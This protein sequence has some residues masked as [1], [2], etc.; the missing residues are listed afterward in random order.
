M[1]PCVWMGGVYP[2]EKWQRWVAEEEAGGRHR[3]TWGLGLDFH[4]FPEDTGLCPLPTAPQRSGAVKADSWASL[5]L[6]LPDL[7]QGGARAEGAE[8]PQRH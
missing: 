2:V 3:N 5:C 6:Y 1:G 4:P 8:H 7:H